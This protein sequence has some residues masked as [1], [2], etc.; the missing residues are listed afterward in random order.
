M[1][2]ITS[3]TSPLIKVEARLRDLAPA[4][5]YA[6]AWINPSV[7]TLIKVYNHLRTI[8]RI[9]YN[10]LPREIVT[11]LPK[12]GVHRFKWDEGAL[13]FTDLAGF[14]PMLEKVSQQGE[15][16]AH[17][18]HKI[19]NEYFSE[20]IEIVSKSGGNLLEFTG[21]ALLVQ[22]PTDAKRQE[23]N[24][25]VRA[26][27]R[28]QNAMK[29]FKEVEIL[30][31]K[32][33]IGM[34]IGL[35][36]GPYLT[37]DIGTPHRMEHVLLGKDVLEAK[38][39][40]SRG[41]IGK[42][43]LTPNAYEIVKDQ[44]RFQEAE[45]GYYLIE[46]DLDEEELGDY[47]ILP[48]RSRMAKLVLVDNSRDGLLEAIGDAITLLEPLASFIPRPVLKMLVENAH[49]RGGLPPE[50]PEATILFINLLGL[51]ED[52]ETIG[53]TG[54]QELVSEF[55]RLVSVINAEIESRGGVMKKVT[56]HHAG[57]DIMSFFGAPN[58]HTNDSARA[59]E[60]ARE[61]QKFVKRMGGVKINDQLYNIQAHIGL[62]RGKVFAAEVGER[63]GR[64]EF[65][66]LGNPVN[67]AAR[68]MDYA[69]AN[70]IIMSES[71]HNDLRDEF[72]TKTHENVQLKG[73]SQKINLYELLSK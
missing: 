73:R 3:E 16:G 43:C 56:Y 50:F 4:M 35:H 18:L 20:M 7:R 70:Q 69:D 55:S 38:H 47:D 25:A 44:Y 51:P 17:I 9:L 71:V 59:I 62:N 54:Q 61:I 48:S 60:T 33:S 14:T 13:M 34:R 68:L 66:V 10:Y 11:S 21:D 27:L 42:V 52:L 24:R 23:T 30:G 57:P 19:L 29:N 31:D 2:Y 53:E 64:R 36:V 67:T 65:N 5:L 6:D 41:K 32:F 49:K 37:A 15:E 39:A 72:P 40:E 28:M 26:G 63:Q 58:S 12:Q 45:D 46:D 8:Y 1:D 22:F